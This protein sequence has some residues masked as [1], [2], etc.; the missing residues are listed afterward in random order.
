MGKR[1]TAAHL[2]PKLLKL[3]NIRHLFDFSNENPTE[4]L[5]TSSKSGTHYH[6]KFQQINKLDLRREDTMY[7]KSTCT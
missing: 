7:K 5:L 2:D 4:M 6:Q 3:E 1:G